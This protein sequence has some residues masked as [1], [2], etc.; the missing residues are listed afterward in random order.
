MRKTIKYLLIGIAGLLALVVIG[1]VVFAMTFD[2]NRY[3]DDIERLAKER[4]GRTLKLA[5]KL[6]V[7]VWP[8]LGAKVNGV[9]LTERNSDQ[10]FLALE[11]AHA[12][13]ALMPLL[14]G[15]VIV[16]RVRVAGL[17]AQLV[18]GKDGRWNFDDLLQ[19]QG[20]KPPGK[21]AA[22]ERG[23]GPVSFDIAGINIERSSLAYRDLA[24]GQEIA[25]GD[26]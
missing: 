3:K 9:T 26:L 16:D 20:E 21:K 1:A 2:P 23:R 13:V 22:D 7:A 14:R 12:S 25:V 24:S 8:A 17:K 19:A 5:G 11:A 18:R 15:E 6:E 10:Q 4:T